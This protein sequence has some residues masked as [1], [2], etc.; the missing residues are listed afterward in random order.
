MEDVELHVDEL[1]LHGF[2]PA[3]RRAVGEAVRAELARLIGE[4]GLPAGFRAA[5]GAARLDGGSFRVSPGH[6]PA[7]VGAA[8][9]RA[10]Y[11][12]AAR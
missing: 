10:V 5:D 4:R 9:A 12:S 11:G 3:D 2:R 1:V 6:R 7:D 8:V